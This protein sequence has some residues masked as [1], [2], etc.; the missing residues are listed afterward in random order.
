[1]GILSDVKPTLQRLIFLLL[2]LAA[3]AL[4]WTTYAVLKLEREE[5]ASARQVYQDQQIRAA[6]DKINSFISLFTEKENSRSE[7][8]IQGREGLSAGIISDKQDF[9]RSYLVLSPNGKL[10]VMDSRPHAIPSSAA[11]KND[12]GKFTH[13]VMRET[14]FLP[15]WQGNDLVFLKQVPT[16][17]GVYTF[18]IWTDWAKL[19]EILLEQVRPILPEADLEPRD[20][21]NYKTES[22]S[23]V[24]LP[25]VLIPGNIPS[26][27]N[28]VITSMEAALLLVWALSLLGAGGLVSLLLATSKLSNRRASFVSAVTHELRTP[29]TNF[30]LYTEMLEEDA[31]PEKKRADYLSLLRAESKRLSHL[32]E[33]VLA[34]SRIESPNAQKQRKSYAAAV[35]FD[36]VMT[37]LREL[38]ESKGF[39]LEYSLTREAAESSLS[40]NRTAVE[41]IL[42][43][44]AD[45]ALKYAEGADPIIKIQISREGKKLCL[46]FSD[47]GPGIPE[48]ARKNLFVP[49]FRSAEAAAGHKPGVGLGLALSRDTA[50]MAG[51][52]LQL[53]HSDSSGTTFLITLPAD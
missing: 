31:L 52:D 48:S 2:F 43:N 45:N 21:K 3:I 36:S 11:R 4:A 8:H 32:V 20:N 53:L 40:T 25:A 14:P 9:I 34:Y 18:A 29:L 46:R 15:Y 42:D 19:K 44:L 38:L 41:Q 37:R 12:L 16:V 39:R 26:P 7:F 1:M 49:F 47:N 30:S 17:N 50:R 22:Y 23:L 10:E 51:G 13:P 6:L 5:R 24:S 33:N 35:L 27:S 28:P